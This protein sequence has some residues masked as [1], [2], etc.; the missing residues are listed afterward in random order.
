MTYSLV[1][2]TKDALEVEITC[3]FQYRLSTSLAD[4]VELF[5]DWGKDFEETFVLLGRNILRDAMASFEALDVFYQ[6]S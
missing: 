4:L 2:R 6:R 1:M 3:S 5:E